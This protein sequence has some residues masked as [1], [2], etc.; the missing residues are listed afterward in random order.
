[1]KKAKTSSQ[2]IFYTLDTRIQLFY[3]C[4]THTRAVLQTGPRGGVYGGKIPYT[5]ISPE[6]RGGGGGGGRAGCNSEAVRYIH[7]RAPII[8]FLSAETT[9]SNAIRIPPSARDE[10]SVASI[11]T[12]SMWLSLLEC[13][14]SAYHV[15]DW[16]GISVQTAL[17]TT[18]FFG[19]RYGTAYK[20]YLYHLRLVA[21][22]GN[23]RSMLDLVQYV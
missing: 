3:T 7:F 2:T 19:R 5:V 4:N 17:P 11:F 8:A 13:F 9:H 6:N 10:L 18:D 12:A 15:I 23:R 22:K 1:M 14:T 21:S 20:P 16:Y